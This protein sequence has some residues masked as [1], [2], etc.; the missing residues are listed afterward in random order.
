MNREIEKLLVNRF[1]I[2]NR[3]ES[4]FDKL[5]NP[6]TR[7]S[8]VYNVTLSFDVGSY[9]SSE[10]YCENRVT[11]EQFLND[12]KLYT[13]VND[14]YYVM[15][16]AQ[17]DGKIIPFSTAFANMCRTKGEY[18]IVSKDVKTVIVKDGATY[19]SLPLKRIFVYQNR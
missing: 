5:C 15:G 14:S 1:I 19:G 3:R 8:G 7:A 17:Y 11:E 9:T 6:S 2:Y 12:I 4:V 13:N 10:V 16:D 18:I